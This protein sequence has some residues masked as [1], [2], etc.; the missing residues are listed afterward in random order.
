MLCC[1]ALKVNTLYESQLLELGKALTASE[2][3]AKRATSD[4]KLTQAGLA[5]SETQCGKLSNEIAQLKTK[6]AGEVQANATNKLHFS[7]QQSV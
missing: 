1:V 3:E 7:Q 5:K 2:A 4:L 6:L